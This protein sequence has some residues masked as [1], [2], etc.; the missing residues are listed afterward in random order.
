ML[1]SKL[2]TLSRLNILTRSDTTLIYA[3]DTNQIK[4]DKCIASGIQM[5][6]FTDKNDTALTTLISES[7]SD[8]ASIRLVP[9]IRSVLRE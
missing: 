5:L 1:K 9:S 3:P 2:L 8:M 7:F 6:Y 4:F